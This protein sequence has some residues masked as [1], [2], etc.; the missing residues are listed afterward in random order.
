MENAPRLRRSESTRN[1][2]LSNDLSREDRQECRRLLQERREEIGKKDDISKWIF[3]IKG[4][5]G[6][7]HV[8][9]FK[10]QNL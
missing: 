1:V 9:A 6:E 4:K 3:R 8:V 2:I 7:F 10:K 5:V